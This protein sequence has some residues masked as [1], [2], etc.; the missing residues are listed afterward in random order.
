MRAATLAFAMALVA[1][2]AVAQT[3]AGPQ[4]PG[5]TPIQIRQDLTAL[6]AEWAPRDRSFGDADRGALDRLLDMAI[7]D[8]DS[9]S[10][11][12]LALVA[13]QAAAI[14]RN[15]HTAALVG[16]I[17]DDLPV[18]AWWFDDGLYIVSASPGFAKLLGA[19]IE[20]LGTLTA[21]E[22]LRRVRPLISGTEQRIRY[23][24]AAFLTSPDV[25]VRIGAAAN[26]ADIPLTVRDRDGGVRVVDL[27]PVATPDPGD[28]HNP[29][30]SGYSVL[31][32]DPADLPGRWLHVLDGVSN[33]PAIYG[34][35]VDVA[36]SW[37][38][39]GHRTLYI[40]SNALESL[41]PTPLGRKMM[42]V[43]RE[44]VVPSRP[45]AV[46]VDLRLNNGGDFFNSVL[47]A[48]ALPRLLPADGKVF[49]LVGRAT[50]SAA[51][52][53]AAMLKGAGREGVTFIGEAMG[54]DGRFWAEG[55]AVT[56]P[57]SHITLRYSDRFED[58]ESGCSDPRT[59]YWATVAFGPRNVSLKPDIEVG[60]RFSDYAAGVDPALDKAVG[61][62]N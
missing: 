50:F 7:A 54:D 46:I 57:N 40:R 43:L 24:S 31:I 3:P 38:G 41:G 17:L 53:T 27:G 55:G 13:M 18:R 48:Q 49:V 35:A 12:G 36:A 51:L 9:L 45:H 37:L 39:E 60:L 59:C 30:F 34:R 58:Y 8:S 47:F 6:R 26:G 2:P 20:A 14:P 28:P 10:V 19:R 11:Q 1:A 23:L 5:L 22:A 29:V 42:D 4:R 16:R 32:P 25:L 52:V 61:L 56:L 21:D 44:M 33:R 15:G 62:A